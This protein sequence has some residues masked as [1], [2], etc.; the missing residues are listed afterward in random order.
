M[1]NKRVIIISLIILLIAACTVIAKEFLLIKNEGE[2]L[3]TDPGGTVIAQVSENS[4]L[5]VLATKED[6][7]KVKG[8]IE[9]QGW[10][11]K[12]AT[13]LDDDSAN[14]PSGTKI[15][16][17]F[18]YDNINFINANGVVKVTGEMTNQSEKDY[19]IVTFFINAYNQAKEKVA[20]GYINIGNFS[21]G[22]TKSFTSV[23][24]GKY[25]KIADYKIKLINN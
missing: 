17:N 12:A 1:M 13:T 4:K 6:W 24:N 8:E 19:H 16:E 22:E 14:P 18:I 21:A 15:G 2:P 7:V 23:L 11:R 9:V 20:S 25:S 3:R 10:V 5:E